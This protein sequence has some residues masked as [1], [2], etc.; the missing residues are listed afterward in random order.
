VKR[1]RLN[2]GLATKRAQARHPERARHSQPTGPQLP[3]GPHLNILV[4]QS[5][6]PAGSHLLRD[7]LQRRDALVA[8]ER[9]LQHA[10]QALAS[11]SFDLVLTEP[12]LPDGTGLA[13]IADRADRLQRWATVLLTEC[14]DVR[15]A[16]SAMKRGAFEVIE[17]SCGP[18]RLLD[19]IASV[20]AR[21]HQASAAALAITVADVDTQPDPARGAAGPRHACEP[22]IGHAASI[23]LL[24]GRLQRIAP[25]PTDVLVIGETGSGKDLVARQLHALSGRRGALVAL[26]CGA[27]PDAL[28]ESELFGHE[29]GAFTGAGKSRV[30]KIEQADHGTL[31]LD[32]IESMPMNQQVKLLRVL[33]SR[34]VGRVGGRGE[35]AIDLRVVAATQ[36]RLD[37]RC[38]LGLFRLDLWHRLNVVAL[39]I[40]S[41]RDRRE[42]VEPLF[43]HYVNKACERFS[44]DQASL[45]DVDAGRLLAHDWPGNVRELKHAAERFV[46]GLPVF[47]DEPEEAGRPQGLDLQLGRCE[48][49]LIR[50]AL[51]RHNSRLRSVAAELGISE[52]T[53]LRRLAEHKLDAA[54]RPSGRDTVGAGGRSSA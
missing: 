32:E 44:I 5:A 39:T 27:I 45:G 40:P 3:S 30:G 4:V 1:K 37:E 26:N 7:V 51:A 29:A 20:Q 14:G 22:I 47:H 25:V 19:V 16:V 38:K 43:V 28:F 41:L 2:T 11:T 31:F 13:L 9:D 36:E 53:L 42:D 33:E 8:W 46:L 48:R 49:E 15:S 52:K 10:R 12:E 21:R 50:T 17:K 34:R 35:V 6:D 54:G 18:Q 23:R 24:R